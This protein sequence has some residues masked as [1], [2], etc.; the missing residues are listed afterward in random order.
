MSDP[1]PPS[2]HDVNNPSGAAAPS[3]PSL[4]THSVNDLVNI[5]GSTA[6]QAA[7]LAHQAQHEINQINAG[8]REGQA[9]E[10]AKEISGGTPDVGSSGSMDWKVD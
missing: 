8:I 1:V 4:A 3:A 5:V 9:T 7:D 2:G 6:A 10:A